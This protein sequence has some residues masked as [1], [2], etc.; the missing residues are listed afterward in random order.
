MTQ[1]Y[2]LD[3][4]H[5]QQGPVYPSQFAS[6]GI[7][8]TTRVWAPGMSQWTAAGDIEELRPYLTPTTPNFAPGG[9]YN[10]YG[11]HIFPPCPPT[12]LVWA[13]LTTLFCCLPFGIISIIYASGVDSEWQ[14]GN[15]ENARRKSKLARNWAIA[16]AATSVAISIIYILVW[17]LGFAAALIDQG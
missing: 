12:N 8:S 1:Y 16:A 13:I 6:L 17:G 5:N 2:Y 3:S 15:Y 11:N 7:N 9:N 10:T 4:N 14:R